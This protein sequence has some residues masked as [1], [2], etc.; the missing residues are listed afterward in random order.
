MDIFRFLL[1]GTGRS[2]LEYYTLSHVKHFVYR[3]IFR[4]GFVCATV[5]QFKRNAVLLQSNVTSVTVFVRTT[6][7]NLNHKVSAMQTETVLLREELA[8]ANGNLLQQQHEN[9]ALRTENT[10][11]LDGHRRQMQV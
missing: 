10:A 5:C 11:L 9:S 7:A 1:Q 4:H 3:Y 2:Q 8:A 6:V